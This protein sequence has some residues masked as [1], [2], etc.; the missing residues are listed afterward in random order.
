MR[1]SCP[2]A[3]DSVAVDSVADA[4]MLLMLVMLPSASIDAQRAHNLWV[5]FSILPCGR[6]Y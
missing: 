3:V 6:I 4:V 2:V 5:E 1:G